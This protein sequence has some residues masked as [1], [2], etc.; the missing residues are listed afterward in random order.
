MT[1]S[2]YHKLFRIPNKLNHI[3]L[4]IPMCVIHAYFLL[5]FPF[6]KIDTTTF[7]VIKKLSREFPV[8]LCICDKTCPKSINAFLVFMKSRLVSGIFWSEVRF[9]YRMHTHWFDPP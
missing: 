7:D 3:S 2:L 8:F 6:F 9:G 1:L 4:Q 5:D